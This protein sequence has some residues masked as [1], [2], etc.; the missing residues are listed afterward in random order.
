MGRL[1]F[2]VLLLSS[3]HNATSTPPSLCLPD[4]DF[5]KLSSGSAA[6]CSPCDQHMPSKLWDFFNHLPSYVWHSWPSRLWSHRSTIPNL[7]SLMYVAQTPPTPSRVPL[8]LYLTS[9][10]SESPMTHT[11][12]TVD[13]LAS[14][15]I[16]FFNW[17]SRKKK[18]MWRA[19]NGS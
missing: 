5:Q 8:W 10:L 7:R 11:C 14:Y 3:R 19:V 12:G 15:V 4:A 1:T 2:T 6:K 16:T 17:K 18:F 9:R 13:L